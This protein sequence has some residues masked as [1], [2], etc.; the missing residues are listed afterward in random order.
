MDPVQTVHHKV[1]DELCNIL[2]NCI[3][4]P[5]FF[6]ARHTGIFKRPW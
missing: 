2:G 6:A 3:A 1:Q 5:F 4:V